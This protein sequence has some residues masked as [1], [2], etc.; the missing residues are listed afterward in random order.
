MTTKKHDEYYFDT[1]VVEHKLRRNLMDPKEYEEHIK[2]LSDDQSLADY[3]DVYEEPAMD[4][5]EGKG[6]TFSA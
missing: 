6:L 3:I 5:N 1:R 2:K 4:E